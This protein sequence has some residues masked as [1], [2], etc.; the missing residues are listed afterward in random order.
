MRTLMEHARDEIAA[1]GFPLSFLSGQR[2]RYRWFGWEAAGSRLKLDLCPKNLAALPPR[3][4]AVRLE[5]LDDTV[6]SD[7]EALHRSQPIHCLRPPSDFGRHLR[8]WRHEPLVARVGGDV[9]GYLVV[10]PDN[11]MVFELVARATDS[12]SPDQAVELLRAYAASHSACCELVL[13]AVPSPLVSRLATDAERIVVESQGN[14]WVRDFARVAGALLAMRHA[15][16]PLSQGAVVLR[17]EDQTF[18]LFVDASG[19]GAS[20][21]S[22][23]PSLT[24]DGATMTR[25]LFGPLP[26]AA[27]TALPA[28]AT[29]LQAWCP[30][31]LA[32]PVQ[33]QV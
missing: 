6:L 29:P 27:V 1:A 26:P 3:A 16:A 12:Q 25:L 22:S 2:Q 20:P 30:L 14:W 31:P 4:P 21:C 28:A 8:N 11:R 15:A 10:K 17:S 32:L 24:L 9:V 5:P 18:R 13:P 7:L 33:D 23:P 19:A